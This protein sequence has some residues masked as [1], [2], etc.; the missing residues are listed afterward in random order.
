MIE[1]CREM[2][3]ICE[4]F[5]Y[6]QAPAGRYMSLLSLGPQALERFLMS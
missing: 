4:H 3:S 6:V 5:A 2:K 1:G